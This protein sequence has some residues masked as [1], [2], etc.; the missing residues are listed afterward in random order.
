MRLVVYINIEHFYLEDRVC[1]GPS[2]WGGTVGREGT[3]PPPLLRFER[4]HACYDATISYVL[5]C[6]QMRM[7]AWSNRGGWQAPVRLNCWEST[8]RFF[9]FVIIHI[10]RV[11]WQRSSDERCSTQSKISFKKNSKSGPTNLE[12]CLSWSTSNLATRVLVSRKFLMRK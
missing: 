10:L 6:M 2:R 3:H 1:A 9:Y 7:R 5:T 4:S 11:E 8:E 12:R